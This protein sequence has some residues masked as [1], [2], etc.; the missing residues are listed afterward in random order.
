MPTTLHMPALSPTMESGKLIRWLVE[1]GARVRS[2]DL[3]AEIETDKATMEFE[4]IDDGTV[5]RL[6]V[7]AGSEDIKVNT[8]IAVL[9]A[10]DEEADAT[11]LADADPTP[12]PPEV[13]TVAGPPV[14][15]EPASTSPEQ[16]QAPVPDAP[17]GRRVLASPL[18][19][20]LA[21]QRNLDL[22]SLVGSGPHG[23]IV[24]ADVLAAEHQGTPTTRQQ[25]T[26]PATGGMTRAVIEKIYAD[27][28]H[29]LMS[30]DG[31]RRTVAQRL[32]ES[33]QTVPHFYLRRTA[34]IDA[35]L[36][37]RAAVN[38]RL[39]GTDTK[40]TINDFIVAAVAQALREVPAANAIW[41]E[42]AIMQFTACDVAVAVAVEG[43][44]YTPVLR[45]AEQLS[46]RDI[47]E[48]MTDLIA[49]ARSRELRPGE[50]VGG[51]CTISN[52][53]MYGIDAFD[54][55]INPPH[56]SILA[57]GAGRR[58]PVIDAA[59]SIGTATQM[60]LGLSVDHRVIDGAMAAHFLQ[61]IANHIEA[62]IL[63]TSGL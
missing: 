19:R 55:V 35:L 37:S 12:T 46:I 44:L 30:L 45:D 61:S 53:G 27:R 20:R 56:S 24:K 62:P 26:I 3:L 1:E 10:E 18:A 25:G 31:M 36:A 50:Y 57:V 14:G 59:G 21:H 39:E 42:G 48:A 51:S 49:R 8:P 16:V 28:P 5:A 63:L 11:E 7:T 52:L 15:P 17:V 4:A 23:R 13:P 22:A 41:V 43:G 29:T 32:T 6:L 2:G 9:V 58:Q 54:A 38:Q 60:T 47:S 33:K 40:L 34:V